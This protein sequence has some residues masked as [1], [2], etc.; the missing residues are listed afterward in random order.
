VVVARDRTKQTH[1]R[2][3]CRG[4]ISKAQ[5]K[6]IL[7]PYV[8]GV[9]HFC[10]NANGTWWAFAAEAGVPHV[11]L[12]LAQ[13]VCKRIY[14]IQNVNGSKTGWTASAASPASS[15]TTIWL[16]SASSTPTA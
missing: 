10:S 6:A 5:A 1:A 3:A 7:T 12:N 8:R 14:H 11:E 2:V 9:S 16:G 13:K 4:Q 15:S